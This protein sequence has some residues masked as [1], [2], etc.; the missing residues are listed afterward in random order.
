[1]T[2][3]SALELESKGLILQKDTSLLSFVITLAGGKEIQVMKDGCTLISLY[4]ALRLCGY[5]RNFKEYCSE[6]VNGECIDT[7]GHVYWL[8]LNKLNLNLYFVWMQDSE[9]LNCEAVNIDRLKKCNPQSGNVAIVKVQSLYGIER[10][11]FMVFLEFVDGNAICLESY[12]ANGKI[13]M[14]SIPYTEVLG[15]RYFRRQST[16]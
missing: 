14:R 13:E 1:M 7:N 16:T 4:N 3:I 8:N 10:R 15:V 9:I 6:L 11:H 12:G 5:S 2:E